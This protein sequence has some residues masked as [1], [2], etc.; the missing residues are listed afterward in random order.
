MSWSDVWYFAHVA[1][2][3][4]SCHIREVIQ[5]GKPIDST[6]DPMAAGRRYSNPALQQVLVP[7]NTPVGS[8]SAIL[9]ADAHGQK[10]AA[11]QTHSMLSLCA[12]A[13][14]SRS[15]PLALSPSQEHAARCAREPI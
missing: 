6:I 13:A 14:T 9:P 1:A 11:Q 4:V 15:G 10:A 3:T 5:M 7:K 8:N 12:S 2:V